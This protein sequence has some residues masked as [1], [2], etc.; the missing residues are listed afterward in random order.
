MVLKAATYEVILS[1]D[2]VNLIAASNMPGNGAM[3]HE[4]FQLRLKARVLEARLQTKF[5]LSRSFSPVE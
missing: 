2:S 4:R 3:N 1:F 5:F